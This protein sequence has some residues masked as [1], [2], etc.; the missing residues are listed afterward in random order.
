MDYK[1]LLMK[2]IHHII[3]IEGTAYTNKSLDC[4]VRG[5]LFSPKEAECIRDIEK[6]SLI[7]CRSSQEDTSS[8]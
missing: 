3:S 4:A 7:L 1:L 6:D 2:Y 5:G 8:T